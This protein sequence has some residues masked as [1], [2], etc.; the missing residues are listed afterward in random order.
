[1]KAI[2]CLTESVCD[3]TGLA[4]MSPGG[5]VATA[6]L[7]LLGHPPFLLACHSLVE[8]FDCKKGGCPR[9]LEQALICLQPASPSWTQPVPVLSLSG[10]LLAPS[11]P[12]GRHLP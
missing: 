4:V 2:P 5:H 10:A 1:M 8:V 9:V 11:V 7:R 3:R 12:P 6:L